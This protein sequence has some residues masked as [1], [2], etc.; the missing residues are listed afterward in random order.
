MDTTATN[1]VPVKELQ[2]VEVKAAEIV[3]ELTVL[4]DR[5]AKLAEEAMKV[6]ER[7][8]AME[9]VTYSDYENAGEL[10]RDIRTA[11]KRVTE[12]VSP[13]VK[14][15]HAAHKAA[16][17]IEN[18]FGKP[19]A[20]LTEVLKLKMRAMIVREEIR[21]RDPVDKVQLDGEKLAEAY[22]LAELG[23]QEEAEALLLEAGIF[24][25]DDLPEGLPKIDGISIRTTWHYKINDEKK[26]PREHMMPNAKSIGGVV[27]SMKEK[28]KIKGISV[29]STPGLAISA[30]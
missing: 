6:V 16:K 30:K 10:L 4:K 9:V 26:I 12:R 13:L 21:G 19:L 29:Y 27:R 24:T 2:N 3:E 14:T 25:P 18:A 28:T 17:A 7:A 5:A 8:G 15:A 11:A 20:A 22:A 23:K 1:L